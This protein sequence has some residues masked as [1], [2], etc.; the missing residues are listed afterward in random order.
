MFVPPAQRYRDLRERLQVQFADAPEQAEAVYQTELAAAL[1]SWTVLVKDHSV[2]RDGWFWANPAPGSGPDSYNYPFVFPA[3][4]AGLGTCLRCHASAESESTFSSLKNI[5]G[6]ALR[7]RVDES[8]RSALPAQQ[9]PAAGENGAGLIAHFFQHLPESQ[10]Q[11]LQQLQQHPAS[12]AFDVPDPLFVATFPP[13]T[14]SGLLLPSASQVQAFPGQWAD[15]VLAAAAGAEH[16]ITSDNCLGC[17]GGLGGAPT[18]ITMFLQTGPDYGDGYNVSEY[19]EWRWSPMGLAGRDPIFYAQLESEFALLAKD[20]AADK[21]AP[22]ATTCLSCHGAAGQRQLEID[23]N[24]YSGDNLDAD[25]FKPGYVLLTTPLTLAEQE[26]QKQTGQYAYHK[27]GNLA[28]EGITCTVCHHIEPPPPD[29]A[30]PEYNGLENFLMNATTG[31]FPYSPADQLN[32]PFDDVKTKPME[33][34]LGI[35]PKYNPYIKDSQLCGSC[36]VINLPNVDADPDKPLQ[37]LT[38]EEQAIL[39]QAARNG[40]AFL[41]QEYDVS[42]PQPLLDF[43]HS[44]EQATFLEWQNSDFGE[45]SCQDCHMPGGFYS[46]DGSVSIS[47]PQSS[48]RQGLAG[49]LCC[50]EASL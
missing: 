34:A 13:A 50:P 17:H 26:Q 25:D 42:W 35:T 6:A 29:P 18:G 44:I 4:G 24:T 15:R 9:R 21:Q 12:A 43:Q 2:S 22:L 11:Q 33:N 49:I 37:G 23:A 7:F 30:H 41:K 28:R 38:A 16:F 32:G 40:A 47:A 10:L 27:Y 1:E 45:Q 19:G 31:V 46:L 20:G 3:S 8:W 48:S 36:H 5:N 39:N 14:G